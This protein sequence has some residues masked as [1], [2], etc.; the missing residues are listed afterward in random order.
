MQKS[1]LGVWGRG[2]WGR[3][4]WEWDTRIVAETRCRP[5]PQILGLAGILVFVSMDP[6]TMAVPQ[7]KE[8]LAARGLP[9]GGNKSALILRLETAIAE[10]RA[11]GSAFVIPAELADVSAA[12]Q[13][14]DLAPFPVVARRV[15]CKLLVDVVAAA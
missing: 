3:R 11:S 14:I 1:A 15:L 8:A 6:L 4:R 10:D 2:G 9:I 7:L 5:S 13:A 12:L